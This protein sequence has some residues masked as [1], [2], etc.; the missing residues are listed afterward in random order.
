MLHAISAGELRAM[1][2]RGLFKVIT[3]KRS[4]QEE[5]LKPQFLPDGV[6]LGES[7]S[8]LL[9]AHVPPLALNL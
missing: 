9:P 6:R 8:L 3:T 4:L 2:R 1:V 7:S 5:Q